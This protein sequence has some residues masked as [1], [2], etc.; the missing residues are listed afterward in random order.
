MAGDG[1]LN[2]TGSGALIP[3]ASRGSGSDRA[4]SP[5]AARRF[6][7]AGLEICSYGAK[8]DSA[9][10]GAVA[11]AW[12]AI[13]EL[14]A[15]A[16]FFV[17]RVA[18]P[19]LIFVAGMIVN[20]AGSVDLWSDPVDKAKCECGCFDQKFKASHSKT[21]DQ[22]G[23]KYV[24][25]NMERVTVWILVWFLLY[26]QLLVAGLHRVAYLVSQRSLRVAPL[27]V[28]LTS[29]YSHFF[30]A[31]CPPPPPPPPAPPRPEPAI[32]FSG[33]RSPF[34]VPLSVTFADR[35]AP[36]SLSPPPP[37]PPPPPPALLP[38]RA[39]FNYL[40]ESGLGQQPLLPSQ[41]FFSLSELLVAACVLPFTD[42]RFAYEE[43]DPGSCGGPLR[44]AIPL[45]VS[46]AHVAIALP[47]RVLWGLFGLGGSRL[48]RDILL[49]AGDSAA[50]LWAAARLRRLPPRAARLSLGPLSAPP[51]AYVPLGA[52]A[53][54]AVY[55]ATCAF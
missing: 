7:I 21:M 22:R 29:F 40:N 54:F 32:P 34:S 44:L 53:L 18:L 55:R 39:V 51:H 43:K 12:T 14:W 6:A 38:R 9:G 47:E 1:V 2:G 31:W 35:D 25:F 24:Y 17:G 52:A 11:A 4:H 50:F 36:L 20:A 19:A 46:A 13:A 27:L 45:V 16:A 28:L 48:S 26:M 49:V 8:S 41:L 15:P 3:L 10:G 23:Y 33:S 37:P 42:A 30:G 5:P